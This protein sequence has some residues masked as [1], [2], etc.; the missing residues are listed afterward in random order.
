M[1]IVGHVF[2]MYFQASVFRPFGSVIFILTS[3]IKTK[4]QRLKQIIVYLYNI[5]V[6]ILVMY[7]HIDQTSAG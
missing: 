5:Y 2:K 7:A 6:D 3:K 1:S 4:S